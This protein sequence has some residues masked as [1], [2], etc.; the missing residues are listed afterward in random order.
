MAENFDNIHVK[1]PARDLTPTDW[2]N[3]NKLMSIQSYGQF[4]TKS[5]MIMIDEARKTR[6]LSLPIVY[7]LA[8]YSR[9]RYAVES[10]YI[11]Q[12]LLYV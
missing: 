3:M 6:D 9:C 1:R 11:E 5:K 12:L 2:K 10:L 7:T 8:Q 4:I